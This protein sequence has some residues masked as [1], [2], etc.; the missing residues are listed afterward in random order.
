MLDHRR[1]PTG[2]APEGLDVACQLA[3]RVATATERPLRFPLSLGRELVMGMSFDS[4]ATR[5]TAHDLYPECMDDPSLFAGRVA[6][7]VVAVQPLSDTGLQLR[8]GLFQV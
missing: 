4:L 8:E 5:P 2:T 7:Q 3:P 6:G 1:R